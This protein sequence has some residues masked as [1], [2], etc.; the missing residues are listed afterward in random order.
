M[1]SAQVFQIALI[2]GKMFLDIV[3]M[4]VIR[5]LIYIDRTTVKNMAYIVSSTTWYAVGIVGQPN[6]PHIANHPEE[7]T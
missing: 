5:S 4:F 7:Q 2:R 3:H 1:E 6:P